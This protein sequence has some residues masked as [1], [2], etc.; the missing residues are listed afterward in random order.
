[1]NR[2]DSDQIKKKDQNRNLLQS[3]ASDFNVLNKDIR[4]DLIK[5]L[6]SENVL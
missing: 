5:D 4:K 1:M 3:I 6:I 2:D